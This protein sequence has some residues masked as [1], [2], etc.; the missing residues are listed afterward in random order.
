MATQDG[1]KQDTKADDALAR[2]LEQL[3]DVGTA[4]ELAEWLDANRVVGLERLSTEVL[5]F[6]GLEEEAV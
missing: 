5:R 6:F 4:R 3:W 1:Q 2:A